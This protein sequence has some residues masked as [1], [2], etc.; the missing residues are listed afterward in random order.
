MEILKQPQS[1]PYSLEHQVMLIYTGTKGYM[2]EVPT[3]DVARFTA[4]L[5]R[6]MDTA[7]PQVG[8][9]IG[10]AKRLTD[11]G[12][13]QLVQAIKDFKAQFS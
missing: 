4:E 6:Y 5:L 2:D 13:E 1:A 10:K 7:A 8:E 12:E 11:S 3:A 9:G